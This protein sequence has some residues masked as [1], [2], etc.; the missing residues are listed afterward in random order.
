MGLFKQFIEVIEWQE[1]RSNRMV[2]QFP[3]HKN[4]IKMGAQ[5][6]VRE[7]QVAI[8]VNE[9]QI[10][11][12]YEPGRYELTTQ[13]MPILT[14]LKSWSYG[15]NS[16]FKAEIYFVNTTQF[17][18]QKWGT[19]NPIMMR[20]KEFGIIRLRGFGSFAYRVTDPVQ[21]MREVFGTNKFAD[22]EMITPQLKKQI[23][24]SLT[25]LLAESGI[26][27]LDLAMHYDE[28][29]QACKE[30]VSEQF[31]EYGLSITNFTIE[32]L[33][34]P[35]EVEAAMDQRTQMG[36]LGDLNKF[37][38]YQTAQAIRDAAN[39]PGGGMASIGAGIGASTAIAGAMQGQSHQSQTSEAKVIC[40]HCSAQV[41]AGSKFCSACG[42]SISPQTKS[43]VSCKLDIPEDA[44]FCAHCGAN[45]TVATECPKC[46]QTLTPG[47]KFCTNCGTTL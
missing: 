19:T 21:F 25:D 24:S 43:C 33:S 16:P 11:D 44:K 6:T 26:A 14:K 17:L 7:S 29:A 27:A 32:N 20:D 8:F 9:G 1:S 5:L 46:H 22:T 47:S 2:Y 13:N 36:V 15:F 28:F 39:N 3:V 35:K 18:N 42:K 34:L 10:A 45:Q 23:L 30:K 38:Q 40:P 31:N 4:E 37:T 41:A 12:V